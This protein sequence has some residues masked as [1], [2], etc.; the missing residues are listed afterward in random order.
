MHFLSG[1]RE[2]TLNPGHSELPLFVV[3]AV[4]ILSFLDLHVLGGLF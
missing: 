2:L 4:T 3:A 1:Q